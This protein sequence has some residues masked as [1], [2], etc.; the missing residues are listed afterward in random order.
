[1]R[2]SQ[3]AS[4]QTSISLSRSF[5]TCIVCV[6]SEAYRPWVNVQRASLERW[7][8]GVE[9]YHVSPESFRD[10]A[11]YT[12][13]ADMQYLVEANRPK[14]V[15]EYLE[16]YDQVI[17]V[18]A[19]VYFTGPFREVL[20]KYPSADGLASVHHSSP[21]PEDGRSPTNHGNHVMGHLNADFQVWRRT[22]ETLRFLNWCFEQMTLFDVANA[23]DQIWL[24]FAPSHV[25]DFVI[26]KEPGVNTAYYN[27]HE[28]RLAK[29]GA[30]RWTVNGQ[31]MYFFQFSGFN[32]QKPHILSRYNQRSELQTVEVYNLMQEFA[33]KF[34]P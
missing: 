5:T 22:P 26:L 2:A 28:R 11:A 6:A 17:L 21:L 19:D 15:L 8:N 7:G 34:A 14:V 30:D 27:L 18:G 9:Y 13:Y 4:I 25:R 20:K 31:L 23:R 32:P 12:Q 24:N 1:M 33:S 29:D 16:K 3:G 10:N